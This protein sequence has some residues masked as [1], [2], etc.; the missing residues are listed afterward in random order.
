MRHRPR[1]S[2]ALALTLALGGLPPAAAE[3]RSPQTAAEVR[4]LNEAAQKAIKAGDYGAAL[5]AY[6]QAIAALRDEPEAAAERTTAM[7]LAAVCLEKLARP[8]EALVAHR[9]AL[10]A[11]L[12]DPL[13]G[14]ARGRIEALEAVVVTPAAPPSDEPPSDEPSSDEPTQAPAP[15]EPTPPPATPPELAP[16][17]TDP[18][19]VDPEAALA[20]INARAKAAVKAKRWDA[21]LAAYREAVERL[22]AMPERQGELAMAWFLVGVCLDELGRRDEA[23]P[24]YAQARALG[25]PPAILARIAERIGPPPTADAPPGVPVRLACTPADLAITVGDL[26]D[27][28]AC[29][30]LRTLPP[31]RW[32]IE[33]RGV[34]GRAG[35]RT[36][37]ITPGVGDHRISL[38]VPPR[39]DVPPPEPDRRAAWVLTVGAAVALGTG[40][41]LFALDDPDDLG[42]EARPVGIGLLALGGALSVTALF[43]FA[44]ADAPRTARRPPGWGPAALTF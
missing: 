10:D 11:G 43:A 39:L 27:G 29:D 37:Q 9:E 32:R 26:L 25:P 5:T 4:S 13:A 42:P 38:V 12:A 1:P 17:A 15:D 33:A 20:R 14:K 34:D 36:V 2:L 3:V 7:F 30:A 40:G 21:A 28:A 16:P 31:G 35:A 44:T 18:L 22:A 8:A 23:D 41:A 24:A 6:R 19:P